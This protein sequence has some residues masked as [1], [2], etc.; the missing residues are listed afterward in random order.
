M[1]FGKEKE[2]FVEKLK[3]LTKTVSSQHLQGKADDL[4]KLIDI[5]GSALDIIWQEEKNH[6]IIEKLFAA[7]QEKD[8]QQVFSEVTD[9]DLFALGEYGESFFGKEDWLSTSYIF[10]FLTLFC[11]GG[12]P[13]PYPYTMLGE[14]LSNIDVNA[15]VQMYDFILNIFP[16]N[17]MLLTSA[18]ETYHASGNSER[19]LQLLN[20]AKEI[21]DQH[22]TETP[23]VQ[24]VLDQI[25]LK[26]D[27]INNSKK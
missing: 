17:P 14:A 26:T 9:D 21:C 5:Y 25:K 10:Q 7:S 27:E 19:A 4:N 16:D 6:A 1:D 13:H 23:E 3:E 22:I 2:M 12:V 11:P 20:H 15:G 8:L 24:T 18:A